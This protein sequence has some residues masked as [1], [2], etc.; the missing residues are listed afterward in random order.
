MASKKDG[1]SEEGAVTSWCCCGHTFKEHPAIHKHV[2]RT[3]DS[4]IKQLTQA[5]YEC[6]LR[7]LEEEPEAQQ[8]N[9]QEAKEEVD[10]SVWIPDV[11]HVS[12][13]QLQKYWSTSD[14]P[15]WVQSSG[16]SCLCA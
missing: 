4:E 6:L 10:V 7:Q 16:H 1:G 8:P 11:S 9:R 2:A 5:T 12:E 3:H 13:E 14:S 15:A